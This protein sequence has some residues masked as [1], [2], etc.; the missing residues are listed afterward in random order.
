ME[1]EKCNS[2]YI[3]YELSMEET[4]KKYPLSVKEATFALVTINDAYEK[5][6]IHCPDFERFM[7][8]FY[9]E[10]CKNDIS[11]G[12]RDWY[13]NPQIRKICIRKS[14]SSGIMEKMRIHFLFLPGFYRLLRIL[15]IK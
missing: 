10:L 14:L 15:H 7:P 4:Y 5:L 1:S 6:N 13:E 3:Y 9:F 8:N 11:R 2:M 12:Y